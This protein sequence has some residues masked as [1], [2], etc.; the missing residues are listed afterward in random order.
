M[1]VAELRPGEGVPREALGSLYELFDIT[2]GILRSYGPTVAQP[3]GGTA[4]S[5]GY[6]AVS[7]LNLVLRP[8]L[9]R[10]RPIIL[11]LEGTSP[12]PTSQPGPP[13]AWERDEELRTALNE[14]RASLTDYANLLAQVAGVPR[15]TAAPGEA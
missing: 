7:L 8:L 2:R 13:P 6:L 14:A 9:A 11:E 10:W 5:F 4:L 12:R 15:L 3:K 1:A